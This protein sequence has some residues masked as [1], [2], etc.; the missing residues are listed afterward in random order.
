MKDSQK[1]KSIALV[2]RKETMKHI[3]DS[4]KSDQGEESDEDLT[5]ELIASIALIVG[6][7]KESKA[8][9][10]RRLNSKEAPLQKDPL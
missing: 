2:S 8:N 3:S 6:H 7:Y 5:N 9:E 4:D 10:V 1:E